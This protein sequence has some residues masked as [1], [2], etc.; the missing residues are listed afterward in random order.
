MRTTDRFCACCGQKIYF[1]PP[2]FWQLIGDFF[3]NVF[4]LDNR[5]FRTLKRLLIP[6]RLTNEFLAG[7]QKPYFHPLRLFFISGVLMVGAYS[8]L[9]KSLEK[10]RL[11][12]YRARFY[13]SL[14]VQVDSTRIQYPAPAVVAA[15]DTI[16]R[17]LKKKGGN[18]SFSFMLFEYHG[19]MRFKP[20]EV[21]F[22]N[23]DLA[24]LSPKQIAKKYEIKGKINQYQLKQAVRLNRLNSGVVAAL[25][26]QSIWGLLLLIP[27]SALL[28]KLMYIRRKR[29]YVEH[30]IFSLHVHTFLFLWQFLAALELYFFNSPFIVATSILPFA[31]YFFL[32]LKQ[33]YK[34]GWGKTAL[35]TVG[36]FWGY[37]MMLSLVASIT[38]LISVL[39]F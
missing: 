20:R 36:L 26:S 10:R 4:N 8:L 3:S 17:R 16:L 39:L 32:S 30:F 9:E 31:V 2:G 28:L 11:S 5:L 7:R 34:Q 18:G 33:V 37:M 19:G 29:K 23:R 13:K 1:E 25:I 24:V 14:R 21:S 15:T 27:F 38:V 12:A 22:K 6:G 35:K